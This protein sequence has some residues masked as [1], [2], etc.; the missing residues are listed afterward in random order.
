M[1]DVV[2]LGT[3]HI[4]RQSV[5]EIKEVFT[6]FQP[7]IVCVELDPRRLDGLLSEKKGAPPL[8]LIRVVGLGGYIFALIGGLVQKKLGDVVGMRPGQEM[9]TALQ[10]CHEHKK[11]GM[12]IDRDILVTLQRLSKAL[13]FRVRMRIFWDIIRSPFSKKMRLD[14]NKVPEAEL[15]TVLMKELK[16]RY[17]ELYRVLLEERNM[18]MVKNIKRIREKNPGAKILVVV[19]AGHVEGMTVLLEKIEES[20]IESVTSGELK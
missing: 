6:S 18:V 20:K 11:Q 7:D 14:L 3:S 17:P 8:S 9:L 13:T 10:L 12:L 2:I 16:R 4:A 15:I 1:D 19:G 5:R